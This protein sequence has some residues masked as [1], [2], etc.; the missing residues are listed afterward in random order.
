[1]Q[2]KIF[3]IPIGDS[4]A[5]IAEMNSFLRSH[6]ALDVEKHFYH[7][8][9]GAT[10]CFCVR[11]I[12]SSNTVGEKPPYTKTDYKN[13]LDEKTFA[14]FSRLREIRKKIAAEEAVPAFA[15]FTDEELS[16]IAKLETITAETMKT[17]KGI[18]DKKM[19]RYASRF[20]SLLNE[21]P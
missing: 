16:G 10:W 2:F 1:M 5:A 7:S 19:E 11:Y 21:T 9:Q 15:I 18:G 20:L 14:V 13:L 6:K 3:T 17:V 12:E 4:G 8:E